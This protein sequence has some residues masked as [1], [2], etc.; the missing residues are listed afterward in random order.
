MTGWRRRV[1]VIGAAAVLH[2]AIS[3]GSFRIGM[4]VMAPMWGYPEQAPA[5]PTWFHLPGI[6]LVLL[7][8]IPYLDRNPS[9]R[10]KDR[11]IAIISGIVAGVVM[12]ILSWMGTP[13]YAVEAAPAVEI[14]QELMPEE[15]SGHIREAGYEHIPIG[16]YDTR[17]EMELEDKHFAEILE[18]YKALI[19]HFE[20][21]DPDFND[22]YGTVE[23]TENQDALKKIAWK[24]YWV[25]ADGNL[26]QFEKDFFLHADSMYWEQ[27]GLKDFDYILPNMEG[28]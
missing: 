8:A 16:L 1:L 15:G 21:K 7:A 9:R 26:D 28:E 18:E 25:S 3:F 23:I 5:G 14:V 27:Y 13:Q 10:A 4:W 11:R 24:I 6:L 2:Y 20:Q 22:A 12:I 19:R 17:A